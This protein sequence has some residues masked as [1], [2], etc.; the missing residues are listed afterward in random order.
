MRVF[1]RVEKS[2]EKEIEWM[3]EII[4]ARWGGGAETRAPAL[5]GA[6]A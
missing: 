4:A 2:M 5:L 6:G 1:E 3:S